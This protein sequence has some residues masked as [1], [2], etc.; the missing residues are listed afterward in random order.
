MI[1]LVTTH[2]PDLVKYALTPDASRFACHLA[3]CRVTGHVTEKTSVLVLG[4]AIQGLALGVKKKRGDCSPLLFSHERK[5]PAERSPVLPGEAGRNKSNRSV[6]G[7]CCAAP[8][9]VA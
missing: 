5:L 7:S 9:S 8:P 6:R 3:G 1:L 4:L 2:S